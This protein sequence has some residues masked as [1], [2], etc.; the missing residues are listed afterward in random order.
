[1]H[2]SLAVALALL[3]TALVAAPAQAAT[4]HRTFVARVGG[5]TNGTTTI[6]AYT[7]GT[8]R[9]TYALKSLKKSAVYRVEVHKGKCSKNGDKVVR[10]P[11][12]KTTS[13]GTL[14]LARALNLTKTNKIWTANYS[15]VLSIR[16]ISGG[17]N[18][19]GNLKFTH[20]TRV[21]I[22]RQ[23]VLDHGID[24]PVVRS[25]K[26]YPYCNVGM[27]M[28]ALNQ[29][30]EPGVTYLF[31]HARKGMFL[32]LLDEWVQ[33]RGVD[34]IGMKVYVYT[35]DNMRY[36]YVVDKVWK[37]KSLDGAY[38]TSEQLWLQTSTGPN[39]TYPKLFLRAKRTDAIPVS[40]SA[41]HPTPHV[42]K[43]G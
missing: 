18:R 39:Y 30:T 25:P 40:S 31:A 10:L 28:G 20:V 16:F 22:P 42:V 23:D 24:L 15:N 21:R 35:S 29:P 13:A 12:I 37:S 38:T 11:D 1:V 6:E 2:R 43:C 41:A 27:Y 3:L 26:G 33:N 4:V 32:P 36:T 34:M 9:V 17:S 5:S 7:D 19:C 8:G 14:S